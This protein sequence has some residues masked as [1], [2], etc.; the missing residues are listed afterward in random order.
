MS[1]LA[2]FTRFL[3]STKSI[4]QRAILRD[5]PQ[6]QRYAS[7]SCCANRV[8]IKHGPQAAVHLVLFRSTSSTMIL[9]LTTFIS[10][11]QPSLTEMRVILTV[12]TVGGHGTV[13]DGGTNLHKFAEDGETSYGSHH[14]TW[15]FASSVHMAHQLQTCWHIRLPFLSLLT[16]FAL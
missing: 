15:V 13:N 3:Q 5:E 8:V 1:C 7:F 16:I 2:L 9:F 12:S 14:P 10:I 4:D 11:D 6:R